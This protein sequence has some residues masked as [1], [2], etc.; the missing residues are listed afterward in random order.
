MTS[1][2]KPWWEKIAGIFSNN[3]AYDEAMQLGYEYRESQRSGYVETI[4]D[5]T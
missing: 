3:P 5:W 4:E 1:T 2:T